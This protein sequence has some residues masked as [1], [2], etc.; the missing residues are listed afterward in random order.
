MF[1]PAAIVPAFPSRL[2]LA[3]A[4]VQAST[5]KAAE[6]PPT[7]SD[8]ALFSELF[9][10]KL[11]F[12]FMIGLAMGF[13]LKVAFKIALFV[14]GLILLA[15]F[16]LQFA[17][18]LDVNWSG[19]EVHY[20]GWADWMGAGAGVFFGFVGDNLTSAASF[21]AGLALGLKF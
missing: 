20:D 8:G 10:L 2:S 18:L 16:A 17:G 4:L 9:F 5:L 11:G 13:A 14:I 21:L 15:T 1:S 6:A 7:T 19:L 3:F 12:S